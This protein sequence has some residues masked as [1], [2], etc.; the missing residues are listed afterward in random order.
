MAG[1]VVKYVLHP[2]TSPQQQSSLVLWHQ[3][4]SYQ[5]QASKEI[6]GLMISSPV[7][8]KTHLEIAFV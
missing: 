3:L 7:V 5:L 6:S 8:N 1:P 4:K 2:C